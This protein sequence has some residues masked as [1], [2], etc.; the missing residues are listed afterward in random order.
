[1]HVSSVVGLSMGKVIGGCRILE[2]RKNNAARA[3]AKR[4]N[5]AQT[6]SNAEHRTES[7]RERSRSREEAMVYVP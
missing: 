1:M 7:N 6:P 5:A 4:A 2:R 3:N